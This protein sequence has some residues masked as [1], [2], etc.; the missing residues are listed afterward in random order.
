MYRL[1]DLVRLHRMKTSCREVAKLLGMSPNTERRYRDVIA[2]AGM[3]DGALD[4]LPTLEELTRVVSAKIQERPVHWAPSSVARWQA[5]IE[6]ML[7]WHR[8]GTAGAVA[9]SP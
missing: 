5:A 6:E 4:E 1:Q 7:P 9:R 8:G 2:E 3:L